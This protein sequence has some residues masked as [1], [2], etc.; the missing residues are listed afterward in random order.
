MNLKKS[1]TFAVAHKEMSMADL[2]E[3]MGVHINQIYNWRRSGTIR[4][5]HLEKMCE[6][7]DMKVSEFIAL[8]EDK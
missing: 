1:I 5:S 6:A 2:A 3:K 8:G 4:Q 7:L